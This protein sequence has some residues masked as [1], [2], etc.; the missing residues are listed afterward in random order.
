MSILNKL[1]PS[2]LCFA[3]SLPPRGSREAADNFCLIVRKHDEARGSREAADNFCLIVRRHDEAR[4]S[5]EAAD[6]FCL[7][8]RKHDETRGSLDVRQNFNLTSIGSHTLATFSKGES[9]R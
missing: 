2:P 7:I 3:R 1:R 8:V 4:G 5:R 6:N 9:K